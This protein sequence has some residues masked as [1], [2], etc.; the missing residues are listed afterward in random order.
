MNMENL[1]K[2]ANDFNRAEIQKYNPDM[3]FLYDISLDA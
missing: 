1:V 2:T 3:E